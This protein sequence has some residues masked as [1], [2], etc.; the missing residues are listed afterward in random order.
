[1]GDGPNDRPLT[2][3]SALGSREKN[4][5][6]VRLPGCECLVECDASTDIS[7]L[8]NVGLHLREIRTYA[9]YNILSKHV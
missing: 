2:S 9:S 5:R 6:A 7:D 4:W 1:M 3:T 8:S